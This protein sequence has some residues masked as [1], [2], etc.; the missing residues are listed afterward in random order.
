MKYEIVVHIILIVSI[1]RS[2]ANRDCSQISNSDCVDNTVNTECETCLRN[3][4]SPQRYGKRMDDTNGL[5]SPTGSHLV[6]M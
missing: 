3:L 4:R 2:L 5:E 6:V 1:V